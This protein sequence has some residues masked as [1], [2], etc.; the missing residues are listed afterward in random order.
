MM[1]CVEGECMTYQ[2]PYGFLS[3]PTLFVYKASQNVN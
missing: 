2:F 1:T 3:F